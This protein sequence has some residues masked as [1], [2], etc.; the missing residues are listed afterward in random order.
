[1]GHPGVILGL[2]EVILGQS[3]SI[4]VIVGQAGLIV[5]LSG[6]YWVELVS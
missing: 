6:S 3:G 2:S 1:M 4:W 5:G